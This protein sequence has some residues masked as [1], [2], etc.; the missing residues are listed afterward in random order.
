[1]PCA[2][3]GYASCDI[4]C[5]G[6][7]AWGRDRTTP[8]HGIWEEIVQRR[9]EK[10]ATVDQ[11]DP[12][13]VFAAW[14]GKSSLTRQQLA[15]WD[16]SARAW[17]R[18]GDSTNRVR[19]KQLKL[20]LDNIDIPVSTIGNVYDS[21]I[22][23]WTSAMIALNKLIE[24]MPH[25]IEN[26]SILLALSAWHLF[27]NMSVLSSSNIF[28]KQDDPLIDSPGVLTLGLQSAQSAVSRSSNDLMGRGITWSLPLAFYRFYGGPV[29]K[30]KAL[31]TDGSRI[32]IAQLLQI[33]MDCVFHGWRDAG[34]NARKAA[35]LMCDLW[36]Y[37]TAEE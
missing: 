22:H 6:G 32:S 9:K 7:D 24:G 23:S 27:P 16:A 19:Q 34:F 13:N 10:L 11:S 4:G 12:L 15:N 37:C 2:K 31:N 14:A 25:S 1:M 36:V 26:S 20:I 18:A 3:H 30:E 8:D 35:E 17:L 5:I 29:Q 21:V 28:I 33:C